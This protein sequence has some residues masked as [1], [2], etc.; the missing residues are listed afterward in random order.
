MPHLERNLT[1]W[2]HPRWTRL[3][4]RAEGEGAAFFRALVDAAAG[5][6]LTPA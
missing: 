4:E 6:E 3:G 1:P 5:R 2:H